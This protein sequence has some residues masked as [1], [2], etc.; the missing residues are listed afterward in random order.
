M[1]HADVAV[2]VDDVL[3]REDPISDHQVTQRLFRHAHDVPPCFDGSSRGFPAMASAAGFC[4]EVRRGPGFSTSQAPLSR[5]GG[6]GSSKLVG[7]RP[8]AVSWISTK[9][10]W[11]KKTPNRI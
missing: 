2:T 3:V 8:R 7:L 6:D 11:R 5:S 4:R 10:G 9:S 1:A